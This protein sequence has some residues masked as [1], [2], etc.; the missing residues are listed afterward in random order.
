MGGICYDFTS[1]ANVLTKFMGTWK[2]GDFGGLSKL[3]GDS[4][5]LFR[6]L[7][8]FEKAYYEKLNIKS[9]R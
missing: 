9:V 4:M 2:M 1:K 3:L 8:D 7:I 5:F 6:S